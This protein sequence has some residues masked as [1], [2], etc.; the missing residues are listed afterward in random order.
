MVQSH[1]LIQTLPNRCSYPVAEAADANA[2]AVPLLV[3]PPGKHVYKASLLGG[4]VNKIL[5]SFSNA[6]A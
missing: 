1:R 2:M 6:P 4:I 3:L 5:D